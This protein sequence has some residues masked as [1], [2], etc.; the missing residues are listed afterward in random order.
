MDA[1][2]FYTIIWI[3]WVFVLV[4][5]VQLNVAPFWVGVFDVSDEGW[6]GCSEFLVLMCSELGAEWVEVRGVLDWK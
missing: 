3:S 5:V 4:L 1:A 2:K 6:E